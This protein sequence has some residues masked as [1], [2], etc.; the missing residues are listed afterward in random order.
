MADKNGRKTQFSVYTAQGVV[1][2]RVTTT[3]LI[4]TPAT[5]LVGPTNKQLFMSES[6]HDCWVVYPYSPRFA[7]LIMTYSSL[8]LSLSISFSKFFFLKSFPPS[9]FIFQIS[10]FPH[11]ALDT[12]PPNSPPLIISPPSLP[13]SRC[14]L[15]PFSLPPLHLGDQRDHSSGRV[16]GS[17]NSIISVQ[18]PAHTFLSFS[19]LQTKTRP[20]PSVP[21]KKPENKNGVTKKGDGMENSSFRM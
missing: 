21:E 16:S 10:L 17:R 20:P 5:G 18:L 6:G 3:S 11:A 12:F 1:V 9:V 15:L 8:Y 19:V 2:S 14:L 4:I 7:P 13:R